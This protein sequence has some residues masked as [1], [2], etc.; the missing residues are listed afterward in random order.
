MHRLFSKAERDAI[1]CEWHAEALASDVGGTIRF[2]TA[3]GYVVWHAYKDGE[4]VGSYFPDSALWKPVAGRPDFSVQ[5]VRA[6]A[7][8]RE[9]IA[10][11]RRRS[12]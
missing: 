12:T 1:D 2:Q 5:P 6:A 11:H 7:V 9:A 3:G 10:R 8:I 4:L